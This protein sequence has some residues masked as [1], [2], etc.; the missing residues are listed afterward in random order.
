MPF[1]NKISILLLR[2][3]DMALLLNAIARSGGAPVS[4][5]KMRVNEKGQW[6]DASVG[7]RIFDSRQDY[8][9]VTSDYLVSGSD[10][11][12]FLKNAIARF[13]TGILVR[14]AI[15]QHLKKGGRAKV[16]GRISIQKG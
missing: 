7:N 14:D 4:G 2:G 15:I 12:P 1:E 11:Y 6:T 13:D 16:E 10:N 8:V 5:I 3:G 9:L